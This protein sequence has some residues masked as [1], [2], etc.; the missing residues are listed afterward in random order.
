MKRILIVSTFIPPYAGG[1]EQVAWEIASRLK[2]RYDVHILTTGSDY[3]E[4]I[5]Q[6]ISIHHIRYQYPL[7]FYYL[8]FGRKHIDKIFK[9][10]NFELMNVHV[11]LPWGYI[12]KKYPVKMVITNHGV[13]FYERKGVLKLFNKYR[14]KK[15]LNHAVSVT[16]ASKWLSEKIEMDFGIKVQR[17]PNGI[18]LK[19]FYVNKDEEQKNVVLFVGRYIE[20]KGIKYLL[21]AAEKLPM[22]EFWFV[23]KGPL[24]NIIKGNN[25]KNFGFKDRPEELIRKATTCIFP[26]I[27]ENAPMVGLEAMACGKPIIA[28]ELGFSEFIEHGKNGLLIETKSTSAIVEGIELLMSDHEFRETL[29]A[30]ARIKAEQYSWNLICEQYANLFEKVINEGN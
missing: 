4:E 10:Y 30:N 3:N 28:T 16:A 8:S 21:E 18:D 17:I 9:R 2:E 29:G 12:L 1:A 20:R 26:S 25:I 14:L 23:G 13:S 27:W 22:Y 19:R 11:I 7:T 24:E 5:R 15:A 6:G